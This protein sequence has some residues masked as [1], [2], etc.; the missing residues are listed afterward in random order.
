[1]THT[2]YVK[3]IDFGEVPIRKTHTEGFSMMIVDLS[4]NPKHPKEAYADIRRDWS[5][6][7]PFAV[8]LDENLEE[9]YK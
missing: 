2:A 6:N 1:M 3:T 5:T 8:L 7:Q 9:V 4:Y